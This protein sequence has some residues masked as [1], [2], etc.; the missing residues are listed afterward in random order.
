VSFQRA[1]QLDPL[2]LF[3][4]ITAVWPLVNL[5]RYEEA[6]PQVERIVE[7]HPDAA[8][9]KEYLHD[10]RGEMYERNHRYDAAVAEMLQG[11]W[12]SALCGD[13]P[14]VKAA[15][16]KAYALA[17]MAGYRHKQLELAKKKY[18]ADVHAATKRSPPPYVSPYRLAE[19]HA[20]VGERDQAFE[21]LEQCIRSRDESLLWLKAE[22]LKDNSP[23]EGI[24]SDPRFAD[25][26]RR[27]GLPT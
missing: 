24:R 22:S 4:S 18:A 2:S 1:R 5:G 27:I 10:L 11:Y 8:V 15:L 21:V 7:M 14:E 25:V 17:G 13:S 9:A 3:I 19:L 20:R 6:I 26:L 23:W 16:G 12:T